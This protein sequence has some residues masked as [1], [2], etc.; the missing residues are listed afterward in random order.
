MYM[1]PMGEYLSISKGLKLCVSSWTRTNDNM[2]PSRAKISGGY[3]NS[4]MAKAEA[5]RLGCDDAIMLSIDGHVAE[6]SAAN[7]FMVRDGMLIT[8]PKYSDVLEGITRRTIIQLAQDSGVK[9]VE[10]PI[11]RTEIY[12]TDEAFLSGTGVQVAWIGEID[13]R[14]IGS[15]KIGPI[16]EKLQ[17]LFFRIVRGEENKYKDWLT[18]I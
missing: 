16:S 8:S 14:T 13:G 17:R 15:G 1:F 5:E 18:K 6:G 7:F 9:V 12:I 10:R 4:S 2:I 3:I 11:D